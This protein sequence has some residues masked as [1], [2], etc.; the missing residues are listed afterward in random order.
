MSWSEV[1]KVVRARQTQMTILVC[2]SLIIVRLRKLTL[3][4]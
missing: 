4:K 1:A 3:Q 2:L